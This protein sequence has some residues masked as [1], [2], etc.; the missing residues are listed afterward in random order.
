M[1]NTIFP[2]HPVY[3][4]LVS[5]PLLLGSYGSVPETVLAPGTVGVQVVQV[6]LEIHVY[7]VQGVY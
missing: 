5:G 7:Y 2:E 6:H 4:Q 3:V 1:K